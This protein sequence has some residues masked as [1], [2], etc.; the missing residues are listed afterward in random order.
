MSLIPI[1]S[2]AGYL[3]EYICA[4]YPSW[5]IT[6]RINALLS[7]IYFICI[8]FSKN[9]YFSKNI[10]PKKFIN[11]ENINDSLNKEN[12]DAISLFEDSSFNYNEFGNTS[13]LK[14]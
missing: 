1:S 14:H 4:V 2:S 9:L 12:F 11:L 3:F 10:F 6:F 7:I 5:R 13:I 8:F